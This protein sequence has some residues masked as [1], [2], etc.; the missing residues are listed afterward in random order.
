M[1]ASLHRRRQALA[2]VVRVVQVAP[3][4]HTPSTRLPP[5]PRVCRR[6]LHGAARAAVI[7]RMRAGG[8]ARG[9]ALLKGGDALPVYNTDGEVL[10]RQ[11]AY[12]HH[13][14]GVIEEGFW[15]AVDT[16]DVS[17][18]LGKGL[19]WLCGRWGK[20]WDAEMGAD[21]EVRA[22]LDKTLT[23]HV[24]RT[25]AARQGTS[26]LFMPRLPE[27]Y[28]VWM[29]EL[30]GPGEGG[31]VGW[32]AGGLVG[33]RPL[34]MCSSVNSILSIHL[35]PSPPARP[36]P[37]PSTRT[38]ITTSQSTPLTAWP[39]WMSWRPSSRRPPP[40]ASTSSAAPTPTAG[41]R[42]RRRR[43]S[44]GGRGWGWSLRRRRCSLP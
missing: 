15:G 1:S 5:T 2:Q 19:G 12:F 38:Q 11:D 26:T 30:H 13:L 21:G 16:R 29:G 6:K 32:L 10:F 34:C 22:R 31:L 25:P 44:R 35:Q 36:P 4:N 28:G 41:P 33:M 7:A 17:G 42:W 23:P 27:A 43:R 3:S 18:W 8:G 37:H 9:V 40:P 24:T 39:T 14:F 20:G